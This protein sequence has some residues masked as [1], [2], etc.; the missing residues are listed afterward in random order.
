MNDIK[1]SSA[2]TARRWTRRALGVGFLLVAGVVS[3]LQSSELLA[4]GSGDQAISAEGGGWRLAVSQPVAGGT[5]APRAVI[6]YEV[7][8]TSREPVLALEITPMWPG[9]GPAAA[10]VRTSATVGRSSLVADLSGVGEGTIDLRVQLVVDGTTAGRPVLLIPGVTLR[11]G[12]PPGKCSWAT[13]TTNN[14]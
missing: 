1:R 7:T 5:S 8:G 9:A 12:T 13:A 10:A 3:S 2:V 11:N 14:H 4:S 6:C